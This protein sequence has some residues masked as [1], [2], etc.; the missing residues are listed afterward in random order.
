MR[1]KLAS[2]LEESE[3]TM[4]GEPSEATRRMG[5]PRGGGEG[6]VGE[7]DNK[8]RPVGGGWGDKRQQRGGAEVLYR[9]LIGV[10]YWR[11]ALMIDEKIQFLGVGTWNVYWRLLTTFSVLYII[12]D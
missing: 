9:L 11:V 5:S 4:V 8:G 12:P 3:A 7:D 10:P 1:A 6:E 2:V